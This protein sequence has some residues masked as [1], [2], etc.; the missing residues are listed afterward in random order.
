MSIEISNLQKRSLIIFV[1]VLYLST[2]TGYTFTIAIPE[3]V[4][5]KSEEEI[6]RW[7]NEQMKEGHELQKQV[8]KE[9]HE[10]RIEERKEVAQSMKRE[11]IKRR[12]I[13]KQ[14]A[15]EREKRREEANAKT[16]NAQVA[17]AIILFPII[18]LLLFKWYRSRYVVVPE[19]ATGHI[20]HN[21]GTSQNLMHKLK[22]REDESSKNK[23]IIR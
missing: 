11:A 15:I 21:L 2:M 8:G 23:K 9:R 5:D 17:V 14:T 12:N 22:K 20:R 18:G 4:Q 6:Q 7:I 16:R 3:S 13:V 10:Q 1:I 19:T